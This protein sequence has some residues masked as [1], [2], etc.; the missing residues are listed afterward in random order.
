[1]AHHIG[2]IDLSGV[3]FLFRMPGEA[4]MVAVQDVDR[5]AFGETCGS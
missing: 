1:M 5:G 3:P 4:D 2:Q